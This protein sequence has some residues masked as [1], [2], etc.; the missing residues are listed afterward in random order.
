MMEG[1]TGVREQSVGGESKTDD[2]KEGDFILLSGT[3]SHDN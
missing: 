2:S 1:F 3:Y